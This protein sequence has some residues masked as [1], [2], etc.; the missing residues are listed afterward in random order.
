MRYL[1]ILLLLLIPSIA[2][3]DGD[4]SSNVY[5]ADGSQQGQSG[6][7]MAVSSTGVSLVYVMENRKKKPS[8]AVFSLEPLEWLFAAGQAADSLASGYVTGGTD[9]T[10]ATFEYVYAISN[11]ELTVS[12]WEDKAT[13][14]A[15]TKI[16]AWTVGGVSNNPVQFLPEPAGWLAILARPSGSSQ[17]LVPQG[18]FFLQ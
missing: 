9:D 11:K 1:Y 12:E 17:F 4:F 15:V 8:N 6:V 2:M 3:A 7:T 5:V 18:L 10:S 16:G 14:S 13:D